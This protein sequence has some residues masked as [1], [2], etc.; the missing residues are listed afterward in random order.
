VLAE[1][2]TSAGTTRTQRTVNTAELQLHDGRW[3]VANFT[4]SP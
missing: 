3:L 4:A 2:T 1:R